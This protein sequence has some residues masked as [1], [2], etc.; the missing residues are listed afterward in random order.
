MARKAGKNRE[1]R[2]ESEKIYSYIYPSN[3]SGTYRVKNLIDEELGWEGRPPQHSKSRLSQLA[4]SVQWAEPI[5]GKLL[6]AP[7]DLLAFSLLLRTTLG[8]PVLN[9]LSR[10]TAADGNPLQFPFCLNG[11][12][13]ISFNLDLLALAEISTQVLL[14]LGQKTEGVGYR[15]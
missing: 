8:W 1:L 6:V 5:E 2:P 7:N 15:N 4:P 10:K 13:A 9:I 14:K 12:A 11:M 3:T